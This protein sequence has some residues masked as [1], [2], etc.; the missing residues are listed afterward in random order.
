MMMRDPTKT[1]C[2]RSASQKKLTSLDKKIPLFRQRIQQSNL[3]K[4]SS[5]D[6]RLRGHK[7]D[8]NSSS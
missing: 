1:P 6:L 4:I 8:D 7:G 3:N 2:P 5:A